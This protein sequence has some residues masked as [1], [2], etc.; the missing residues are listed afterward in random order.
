MQSLWSAAATEPDKW[1]TSEGW[2]LTSPLSSAG[3]T[4]D[5]DAVM[6]I[7]TAQACIKVLAETVAYLPLG[8]F[9]RLD[10]DNR[11]RARRHP[12]YDILHSQPNRRQTAFE[13][14]EQMM[15]HLLLRGNSY[16]RIIPGPRGPIDQLIPL[17]PDRTR[18]EQIDD[19]GTSVYHH[20]DRKGKL[21]TYFEDEIFHVRG[22]TDNGILGLAQLNLGR[23]VFGTAMATEQYG[24]SLFKNGAQLGGIVTVP[25]GTSKEGEERAESAMRRF[26]GSSNAFKTMALPAGTEWQQ[27]AMSGRDAEYLKNRK[28][29][30]TEIC[31]IFR[32]PPHMI[33]DLE[34][35]T[36]SNIEE[37]SIEFVVYALGPWLVRFE[38]AI[39]R[40]LILRK[41]RFFAE[42]NVDGLLR[43]DIVSRYTAYGI[44]IE[45][46]FKTRNEVRR[47]ENDNPIDGLNTPLRPLNMGNG[48]TLPSDETGASAMGAERVRVEQFVRGGAER[49][50][51]KEVMA[52]R[53]LLKGYEGE[54][55]VHQ[56]DQFYLG[57][58]ADLA[59]GLLIQYPVAEEF[60]RTA[61]RILLSAGSEA[62]SILDG[63]QRNRVFALTELGLMKGETYAPAA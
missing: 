19:D 10:D 41:D 55:L 43:G 13:W 16:N 22:M 3:V 11:Q 2:T 6:R 56:L 21:Q 5:A 59:N 35:A 39:R 37:Q 33:A 51:N 45:K 63:W 30:V 12:L 57:Y 46:G 17:H 61:K 52:V 38:Q 8:M 26:A 18:K 58:G 36:F 24:A 40:D 53:K 54:A 14:R 9:E 27:I 60:A 20:T 48:A 15:L 62:N 25:G 7:A 29:S 44:A 28:F 34:K 1:R 23:D 42:F 31:R 49:L 50:A 4:V 32:V 47:L